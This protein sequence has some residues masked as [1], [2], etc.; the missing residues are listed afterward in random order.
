MVGLGT[1][2]QRKRKTFATI[3]QAK[4]WRAQEATRKRRHRQHI[5]S[6]TLRDAAE[7]FLAGARAGSIAT[8]SGDAYRPSVIRSYEQALNLNVLPRLGGMRLDEVSAIDLQRMIEDLRGRGL[9]AS[10]IRNA[11]T[12]LR[13]IYRRAVQ[14][15]MAPENPTRSVTLPSGATRRAH[16][17]DP[18]SAARMIAALEPRD[19][20]IWAA[21]FYAGLR[22]GELRALRW[23]DVDEQAGYLRVRRSWDARDGEIEPKSDAGIRDV[24]ILAR[25][26]PFLAAQRERCPWSDEP[27]GLVFGTSVRTPFSRTHFYTRAR[28]AWAKAGLPWITPHQARHSFASFLI[29]ARVDVKTLTTYMGHGSARLSLDTYGHLFPSADAQNAAQIDN[30]LEAADTQSRVAQL[31]EREEGVTT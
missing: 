6:V 29:A 4:A 28:R 14:L 24:P 15:G 21:A 18:A 7:E 2:G 25:L 20:C 26:L 11:T 17:G 31:E 1:R 13:A 30:W 22:L 3:E 27:N 23:R 5:R 9:S 8:R 16:G 12:P 19:Q 10:T